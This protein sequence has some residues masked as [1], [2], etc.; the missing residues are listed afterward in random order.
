M[1]SAGASIAAF[2]RSRLYSP[3]T[4]SVLTPLYEGFA[5]SEAAPE[6]LKGVRTGSLTVLEERGLPTPRLEQWK[7]TNLPRTIKA[8]RLGTAIADLSWRSDTCKPAALATLL[9]DCPDW[10]RDV[11][12]EEP[13]HDHGAAAL[14][15]MNNAFLRDGLAVDIARGQKA[16]LEIDCAGGDGQ[17]ISSCL[18]IRVAGGGS[19]DLI[20]RQAGRGY[21]WKSGSTRIVLEPNAALRHIRVQ[22]DSPEAVNTHFTRVRLERDARYDAF[23]LTSGGR[24]SRSQVMAALDGPG[25]HCSLNSVMLQ[26]GSQQ[27]DTAMLVEHRAANCTSRQFTRT[28]LDDQAHGVCQ[29]KVYVARDAQKTDGYQ[30]SN[31]LLLSEGAEMDTKPELE[32]YADDVKCSHGATTGRLD[33]APLFYMR[34]RGIPEEEARALL[35]EAFLQEII[36]HAPD[37]AAI[38]MLTERARAWMAK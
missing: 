28:V 30:L 3:E 14:W 27:A 26:R 31:T 38:P 15:H 17:F 2:P 23:A 4:A 5:S 33:E 13:G 29:G 25:A 6:W 12:A 21:Y 7:Y 37:A 11:L 18:V 8:D 10:L 20:E 36:D 16:A 9:A 32:I 1:K 34:S 22:E 24:L 19:L 35:I